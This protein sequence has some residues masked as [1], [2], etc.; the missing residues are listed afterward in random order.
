MTADLHLHSTY[1]DGSYTPEELVK[2]AVEKDFKTIAIADHDTVEGVAK[3]K[4]VAKNFDIEIIP[5]IEFST[6]RDKAEIHILGYFIDYNDSNLLKESKKIFSARKERAREMV[7]LLNKTGVKISFEQVKNI[8]GDDYLGRPHVA[9]AMIK[10]GYIN[11]IGEAF[12]EDYIGNG[13]KAYVPKYKL[14]PE[15][16]IEIINNA[17]GIAVIAHP[18]FI[19]HGE[20]MGFE[21][22]KELKKDGLQGIEVYQSKHDKKAVKKYKKIAENL[23]LLITGGS[24]FHGEN[25]SDVNLGDI[26]LSDERVVELKKAYQSK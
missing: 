24:D 21:D 17:G 4:E 26:R 14:S 1:S 3:A 8:A 6:F 5:A 23:D 7:E 22:I 18:E 16:A 25:S 2:E 11:E 12:T 20:A 13:G 10:E 9:K 19:N 15:K